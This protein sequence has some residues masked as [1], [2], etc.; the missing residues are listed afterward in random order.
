MKREE[1][2]ALVR[3]EALTI[4][5]I[6]QRRLFEQDLIDPRCEDREYET[7][8]G[9]ATGRIWI[10]ATTGAQDVGIAYSEKDYEETGCRW[11][12]VFLS[13]FSYGSSGSWYRSL[14]DLVDDCGYY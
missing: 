13:E 9:I 6:E 10:V 3:E 2:A 12:L 1:V 8:F 7:G 5:P 14:R 4:E 11:G